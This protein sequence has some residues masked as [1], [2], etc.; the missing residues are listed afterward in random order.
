MVIIITRC[1]L[2]VEDALN[3]Y[4]DGSSF[5]SPRVGGIGIRFIKIDSYGNEQTIDFYPPGYKNATNN[6][7]ELQ[8]CIVALKEVIKN[9]LSCGVSR[10]VI[11][12]DSLYVVENIPKAKFKW[13]NNKWF[14]D[15][16]QPV[17]NAESWIELVKLIKKIRKRVEFQWI[18]G[19]SKDAHNRAVDKIARQSAKVPINKAISVV[20]VR[21]KLTKESVNLG[22]VRMN[23]QR[24]SIRVITSE[25]LR[26]QKINKYK[27]EVIA[28]ASKYN[29][30][31]DVI[32]SELDLKAG[33]SY[34]VKLNSDISNPRI[35]KVF[36]EIV[37]K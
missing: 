15:S 35:E 20:K 27:Y 5:Q 10:I 32:Y 37:K 31:V 28:K 3:I 9:D 2:T 34:Y 22:S 30:C 25:Y 8:A 24:L 36:K 17:L 29:K 26:I 14:L 19:H 18:K 1:G 12:T 13:P 33:H 21:R 4:T 16:G 7:M 6:Q 11:Y 23:S